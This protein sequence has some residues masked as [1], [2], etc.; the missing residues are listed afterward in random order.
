MVCISLKVIS[1]VSEFWIS[2]ITWFCGTDATE[3]MMKFLKNLYDPILLIGFNCLKAAESIRW[4]SLL[5]TI[6]FQ[7]FPITHLIAL[8]K[9]QDWV[10][11]GATSRFG[12]RNPWNGIP[13]AQPRGNAMTSKMNV[14][15]QKVYY[16]EL[17]V[18][19]SY[20]TSNNNLQFGKITSTGCQSHT[21]LKILETLY[22]SKI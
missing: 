3:E 20:I 9:M 13:R 22:I 18:W 6:K 5:L 8:R 16:F 2:F 17:L 19:S 1:K 11:H 21:S 4:D 10:N 12:N 15:P 7:E 14:L